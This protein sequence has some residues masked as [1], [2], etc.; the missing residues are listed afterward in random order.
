MPAIGLSQKA[1]AHRRLWPI[2]W[3]WLWLS[4]A[5]VLPAGASGDVPAIA[6]E[7]LVAG[8]LERPLYLTHAGDGTGRLFILEQP[9]R[10]RIVRDGQLL[11]AP[12][13]DIAKQVRFAGEQGLLGL[14]FHPSYKTNGRYFIHYV[15]ASDGRT[16]IAEFQASSNPD[17]S[18]MSEKIILT[19]AQP[20]PNHKGGMIEFGPDGFLYLGLGDGGSGGDPENR[21][22]NRAELL[23]KILR[24]DVDHGHPYA[25]PSDNPPTDGKGR[26]EIYATGLR[27]P[28]R[29]SFDRQ[30]GEL[31]AGDVGQNEWEEIDSIR[32]G[33]NY[34]W[35]VME[36]TH[37]YRPRLFCSA[38]GFVP[39]VVEYA[40]EQGRCSVTGGYVYRG[41]R[42]PS[43]RGAYVYGDFCSGEVFL[44]RR[45]RPDPV[46]VPTVLL[47]TP[48]ALS[49]F[50]Q[51]AAGE[52][53][54]IDY[55]GGAVF[56]VIQADPGHT[57]RL[58]TILI[59]P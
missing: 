22:Q 25:I 5:S 14:A 29:F 2:V 56:R 49:S 42:I 40:H 30:T 52:L 8:G 18:G 57:S 51:D 9:G 6:L 44:F 3:F 54:V 34:G 53:Y 38:E 47:S 20:Y 35:R 4:L 19:V 17:R 10:I 12:F 23:G 1:A 59:P 16:V 45:A 21:A 58:S 15:R 50:G 27:N 43:L 46:G 36:G 32:P 33:E 26:P 24:V 7:P 39:P 48:L 55:R 37:C 28:W 41:E 13:L 11:E 31:W